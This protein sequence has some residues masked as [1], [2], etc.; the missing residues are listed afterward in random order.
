MKL[1]EIYLFKKNF[2]FEIHHFFL[3]FER[4][5][6]EFIIYSNYTE[7]IKV[8]PYK[9]G[10]LSENKSSPYMNENFRNKRHNFLTMAAGCHISSSAMYLFTFTILLWGSYEMQ[11]NMN[12]CVL[13]HSYIIM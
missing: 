1:L 8:L 2:L 11:S 5:T 13:K 6:L 10:S 3:I 9:G 7:K 12:G 4:G